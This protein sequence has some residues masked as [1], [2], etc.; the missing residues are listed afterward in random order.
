LSATNS[1]LD[2]YASRL[3]QR[4]EELSAEIIG[5]INQANNS[6]YEP[7]SEQDIVLLRRLTF[8]ARFLKDVGRLRGND[9]LCS[10]TIGKLDEPVPLMP[11]DFVLSSGARIYR[12]YPLHVPAGGHAEIAAFRN[13]DVVLGTDVFNDFPQRPI[14]YSEGIVGPSASNPSQKTIL[15]GTATSEPIPT[16]ILESERPVRIDGTLFR[17][18]CSVSF[19]V[20]AVANMPLT[21]VW[22]YNR[23]LL[24]GYL[25]S[26]GA[27]G[28]CCAT[29]LLMAGR[30]RRSHSNQLKRAILKG[31]LTVAYQPIVELGTHRIVGAEALA[32]WTDEEGESIR[33]ETI[34]ALAEA[35]GFVSEITRFILIR[36]TQEIRPILESHP[37]FRLSI[38]LAPTD[39]ADPRLLLLLDEKLHDGLVTPA[40]VAFEL[41]ERATSDRE[42][43]IAAIR[44]LRERG[45]A[46]FIDD[47]G[48]GYS[49]LAYLTE[50]NVDGIKINRSFIAT[51]G[52]ESVTASIVPQIL[53]VA[54]ALD[55]SVVVQGIEREDQANYFAADN[56]KILGQGWFFG[57]PVP[58]KSLIYLCAEKSE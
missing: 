49:N 35:E 37:N 15:S 1:R 52:T 10:A 23:I 55:L 16:G 41:S 12:S 7:C 30:K 38:N 51:I 6:P 31:K 27:A 26:G 13:A 19:P 36:S 29:A 24:F 44:R 54:E 53:A 48:T 33:P 43:A 3:V 11:P 57:L 56:P 28:I 50:L 32:R 2:D 25:A 40:N 46:I 5:T 42:V 21:D 9:L 47:F 39:L 18:H 58:A 4:E 22:A 17:A 14:H 20:C 8:S 45:H 34:L